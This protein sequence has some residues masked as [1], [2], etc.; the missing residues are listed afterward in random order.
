MSADE[1][2]RQAVLEAAREGKISCTVA[3]KLAEELQVKPKEI[4]AA[5]NE[6]KIKIHSCELGCF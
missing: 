2:I 4:G 5:C 3:R 1:K 6:L